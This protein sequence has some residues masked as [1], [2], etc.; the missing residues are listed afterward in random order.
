MRVSKAPRSRRSRRARASS[1]SSGRAE[2]SG[3]TFKTKLK[4][5]LGR[6]IG[7]DQVGPQVENRLALGPLPGQRP[8]LA[9][10]QRLQG[11]D[12]PPRGGRRRHGNEYSAARGRGGRASAGNGSGVGPVEAGRGHGLQPFQ[13]FGRLERFGQLEIDDLAETFDSQT[14][15]Q[16]ER[17]LGPGIEA[18]GLRD[19]DLRA[20]K[21]SLQAAQQIM[22]AD[23]AE[24]TAFGESQADL[25]GLCHKLRTRSPLLTSIAAPARIGIRAAAR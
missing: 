23:Q 18:L 5:A 20:A 10:E 22:V 19:R 24:I 15:C 12:G 13:Q 7:P 3:A 9:L 25:G 4:Q 1:S 17:D 8:A 11:N 6:Q 21:H 2:P 16:R 14:E